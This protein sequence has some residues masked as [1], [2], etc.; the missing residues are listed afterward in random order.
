MHGT[1]NIKL[2]NKAFQ[3][4]LNYL[5]PYLQ[6]VE[7]IKIP[8]LKK[9]KSDMKCYHSVQNLLSSSFLSKNIKIKINRTIILPVVLFGC[10]PWSTT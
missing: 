6:T 9:M 1:T 10:E 3:M 8:Y 2:N 4:T 5:P 7:Q